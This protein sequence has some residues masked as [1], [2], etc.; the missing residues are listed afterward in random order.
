LI[1]AA[2]GLAC[3]LH[4]RA[5][6][7]IVTDRPGTFTDISA[8]GTVISTHGSNDN[9]QQFTS[10]VTNALVTTPYLLGS[11]S[12]WVTDL[13]FSQNNQ[14]ANTPLPVP[15]ATFG[16][17]P[18][19]DYVIG[20]QWHQHV[21]EN[22]ASVEVI[23]WHLMYAASAGGGS[24]RGDFEVKI[25]DSGPIVAQFLYQYA[26]PSWAGG[27]ASATIG[28]QWSPTDFVQFSLNTPNAIQS[29]SVLSVVLDGTGGACCLPDGSCAFK[30]TN[31]CQS[32]GGVFH[33]V[34]TACANVSC[35]QPPRGACCL[36]GSLSCVSVWQG[37]C[38]AQ[39]GV[40]RGDGTSCALGGCPWGWTEQRDAAE[41]PEVAQVVAGAGP[42]AGIAGQLWDDRDVDL[43]RIQICD[44]AN[45]SATTVNSLT[46]TG[47][48][49]KLFLF[50]SSGHGVTANDDDPQA[51]AGTEVRSR[52]TSQFIPGNGV[53]DLAITAGPAPFGIDTPG[54]FTDVIWQNPLF[55]PITQQ[56]YY[57]V[58]H[59][60][61][62]SNARLAIGGWYHNTG[63]LG[64]YYIAL[65]GACYVTPT[66]SCYA[67]CDNSTT[68][69]ILNV[70]DFTCFL[71]KFAAGC[72]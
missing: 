9:Q 38:T 2:C 55:D 51:P 71:Q 67:N 24:P 62:G 8:S 53:Y 40:Y 43:Y 48:D 61:D 46:P 64:H 29:G 50:D 15:V 16:L 5:Q 65:T 57:N 1:T 13:M 56:P 11:T 69:P 7:A 33:G 54:Y 4:V 70:L 21:F 39:G 35:P 42:L 17:F 60:P 32:A 49:T 59:R 27:G 25:F 68:P 6:F 14:S 36:Q 31:T 18:F 12:G 52:L 58:E 34:G 28:V 63:Q 44:A 41:Y 20:G 22:E 3:P 72:P 19:W 37:G 45:F 47:L 66:G 26:S 30:N 23:Q 10:S